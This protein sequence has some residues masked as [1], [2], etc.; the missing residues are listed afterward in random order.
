MK[1]FGRCSFSQIESMQ[2]I[3]GFSFYLFICGEFTSLTK[4]LT[5]LVNC[6]DFLIVLN[7]FCEIN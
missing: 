5:N 2:R 6:H 7:K 1:Y 4:E 3:P